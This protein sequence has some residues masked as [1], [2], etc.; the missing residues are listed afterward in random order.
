MQVHILTLFPEMFQ[1][2]FD[3]S[4]LKRAVEKGAVEI[5][6]HDIR[7]Y[8][9]DRHRTVDD[10]Q[11]G[12]DPGMVMKPEPIFEGV[13]SIL[14]GITQLEMATTRVILTSPQ[15]KLLDQKMVEEFSRQ[16]YLIILCGHYEG[17]DERVREHLITDDVSIGDYVLTGGELAAMAL[18]DAVVRLLP[19]VVGKP[20]SV[21]RDSI[22]SGLLQHPVY[23]RPA[24]YQ[25]WGVPDVLL[26]GNHAEIKRWRRERSLERTLQRRPDL[27]A[28]ANLSPE[29][30]AF[31]EGLGYA[32][33]AQR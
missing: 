16:R 3:H 20:E 2:P 5:L 10:Y 6:I 30:L 21:S 31:L 14:A 27:L 24:E 28:N 33:P 13:E 4:I 32:K 25:D 12:G 29:D 18:T 7:A 23:T 26:S 1:G 15:G 8:A 9:H 11:F 22:T 19:G 17:V